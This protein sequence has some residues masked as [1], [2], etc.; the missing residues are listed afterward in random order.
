MVDTLVIFILMCVGQCKIY[1]NSQKYLRHRDFKNMYTP[2]LK[3]SKFYI[4]VYATVQKG[5]SVY[6]FSVQPGQSVDFLFN[7]RNSNAKLAFGVSDDFL[8]FLRI[9][10]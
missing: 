7:F 5:I 4:R 3:F 1:V 2:E 8:K 10:R 9:V 6:T